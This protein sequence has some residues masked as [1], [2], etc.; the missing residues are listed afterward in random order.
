MR[1]PTAPTASSLASASHD[2]QVRLWDTAKAAVVKAINAHIRTQPK[3]EIFPVYTV[4]WSSNSKFVASAGRDQSVKVWDAATGNLHKEFKAYNEKE[5]PNGHTAAVTSIAFTPNGQFLL[6]AGE[7]R[8]IRVWDVGSG[9]FVR[10][11]INPK[12]K[13]PDGKQPD[14]KAVD[15]KLQPIKL[16]PT[17]H[18][19]TI[20]V[21]RVSPDGK[22]VVSGG[23]GVGRS[24]YLAIWDG[25]GRLQEAYEV[26]NGWVYGVAF[27][28][29]N[30]RL[31]V[32]CGPRDRIRP[33]AQ[34]LILRLPGR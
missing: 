12:I 19:G 34:A 9:Q 4:A 3:Q 11:F 24:G 15:P 10:Q 7:D 2:G 17:A 18:P 14:G 6:S 22:Q 30:Q 26:P 33:S 8:S 27:S 25:E 29:D 21:V 5:S 1:S 20:H 16:P 32:A 28:S 31:A 13:Q 23:V